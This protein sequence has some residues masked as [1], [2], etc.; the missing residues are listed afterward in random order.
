MRKAVTVW[1]VVMAGCGRGGGGDGLG[2]FHQ[3]IVATGPEQAMC[4]VGTT[5]YRDGLEGRDHGQTG[6]ACAYGG[7]APKDETENSAVMTTCFG[8]TMVVQT[9]T[10]VSS[11]LCGDPLTRA[12]DSPPI[13]DGDCVRHCGP[14]Q[15][16]FHNHA[17][18]APSETRSCMSPRVTPS[19]SLEVGWNL[20]DPSSCEA[21]R[22]GCPRPGDPCSGTA[23]CSGLYRVGARVEG[24]MELWPG[25]GWCAGGTTRL[26]N[27]FWP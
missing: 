17:I 22:N 26:V 18:T 16:V 19:R 1:C 6:E 14:A 10:W 15:G 11:E 9:E 8:D 2:D 4:S 13:A 20:A 24:Q 5:G 12:D 3:G 25:I 7:G 23:V 21:F 27:T